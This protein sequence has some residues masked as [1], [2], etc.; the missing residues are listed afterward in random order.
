M[1]KYVILSLAVLFVL[2]LSTVTFAAVSGSVHDLRTLIG[3]DKICGVCHSP[4]DV[5]N[6][7]GDPAA[8]LWGHVTDVSAYTMYSSPGVPVLTEPAGISKLCL[9]C[10]DGVTALSAYHDYGGTN[11]T[12]STTTAAISKNLTGTHPISVPYAPDAG[13]LN[14]DSNLG[15]SGTIAENLGGGA[16][17]TVEC[18]TCHDVHNNTP[19]EVLGPHLLR[20]DNVDSLLCLACHIK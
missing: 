17:G 7:N 1:K 19:L 20:V 9:G 6:P 10:H 15:L 8:P 4:H 16:G 2:A 13:Y 11:T 18:S 3:D 5:N 12:L 14:E